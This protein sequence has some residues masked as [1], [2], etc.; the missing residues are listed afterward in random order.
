[1]I[2]PV[3]K[4]ID[5]ELYT[6]DLF[7]ATKGQKVFVRLIKHMGPALAKL[8]KLS[9]KKK[10]YSD[11]EEL[12]V[13]SE[14]LQSMSETLDEDQWE[15]TA[16][17]LRSVVTINGQPISDFEVRFRGKLFSLFKL[18]AAVIQVNFKDFFGGL[19][20]LKGQDKARDKS[21]SNAQSTSPGPSG[22]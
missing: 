6:V 21:P 12:E 10:K 11:E 15:A 3:E 5:D 22:A 13:V 9:D 20:G 7:T 18:Y 2:E 17:M 19:A 16:V 1:M 4:M 8:F 14:A